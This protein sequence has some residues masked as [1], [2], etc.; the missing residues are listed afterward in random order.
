MVK[1]VEYYVTDD[2]Y[3]YPTRED[4]ERHEEAFGINWGLVAD[5]ARRRRLKDNYDATHGAITAKAR[6]DFETTVIA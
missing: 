3:S 1:K 5:P 4:A 2:G 6:P